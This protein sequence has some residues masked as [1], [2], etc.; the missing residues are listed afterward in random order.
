MHSPRE[1]APQL[2]DGTRLVQFWQ[3]MRRPL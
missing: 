2:D 1:R 3:I